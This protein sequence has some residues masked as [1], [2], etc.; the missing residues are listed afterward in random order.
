[1]KRY[2]RLLILMGIMLGGMIGSASAAPTF[3]Y[4]KD[5]IKL[6]KD[7]LMQLIRIK[8]SLLLQASLDSLFMT[9]VVY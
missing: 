4:Y 7:S 3:Q 2:R 1:M 8:D 9:K 6:N 5:T